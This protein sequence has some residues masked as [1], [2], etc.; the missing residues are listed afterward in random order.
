MEAYCV[1]TLVRADG[2]AF[3][4]HY[5]SCPRRASIVAATDQY[6]RSMKT[7]LQ[8]LR[9]GPTDADF[10]E[11]G[12]SSRPLFGCCNRQVHAQCPVLR[13]I[14][15]KLET[16]VRNVS[17]THTFTENSGNCSYDDDQCAESK[18][19]TSTVN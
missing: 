13:E 14:C 15:P 8:R 4:E 2:V 9:G 16:A 7:A 1:G 6:N 10:G 5:L 11:T 19:L 18:S 3:E 12:C 17:K